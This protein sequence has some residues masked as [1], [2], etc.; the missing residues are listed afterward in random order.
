MAS[1]RE[2]VKAGKVPLRVIGSWNVDLI[3]YEP[4]RHPSGVRRG[5]AVQSPRDKKDST[6][7]VWRLGGGRRAPPDH[8]RGH[9]PGPPGPCRQIALIPFSRSFLHHNPLLPSPKP[10]P[11]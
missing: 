3:T 6:A 11:N 8:S 2:L 7:P 9:A 5:V 4:A 10:I 1:N